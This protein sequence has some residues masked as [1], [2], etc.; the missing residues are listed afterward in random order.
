MPLL[1]AF[2][3]VSCISNDPGGTT[4]QELGQALAALSP[5]IDRGEADRVA[6]RIYFT[7]ARLR[8]E[9]GVTSSAGWHNFLIE[10]GARKKGYCFHY[11]ED[12]LASLRP[13]H[14]KTLDVHWA[15][16][17]PGTDTESNCLIFTSKGEPLETGILI[18]A[19]REGGRVFWKRANADRD[20][21][22][23]EDN[24]AYARAR[25]A[26]FHAP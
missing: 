12:I 26:E 1:A 6:E 9:Y 19:W 7:A 20:Y 17:D 8:Q 21:K 14:V 22:W 16:A 18:D 10:T 5:T 25:M 24:S 11:A 15:T 2:L 23:H 13:L 3:L 4:P